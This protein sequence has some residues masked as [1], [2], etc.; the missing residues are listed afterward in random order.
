MADKIGI[1]IIGAGGIA[2]H[3]H[4][5]GYLQQTDA[6]VVAVADVVPERAQRLAEQA[7]IPH[8][9]GAVE[10]LL[11]DTDVDAVSVTTPNAFHGPVTLA[12][13]EAGKHVFCEKPPATSVA[14]VR[15]MKATAERAGKI[16]YFCLNNRFRPDVIQLR[17]YVERGELGEIYYAKTATLRRR[18]APGGW[19]ADKKMA[20]GGALID[21]GVHCIDWTLWI[22][23]SP[24]PVEIFGATYSKIKKYE[25]D[26]HRTWSPQEVRGQEG[27]VRAGDVDD[28]ATGLVRFANGATLFAE[29]SWSLNLESEVESTQVFGTRAGATLQPLKLFRDEY[30]R[31]VNLEVKLEERRG[32]T[33]HGRAIRN[34]LDVIQ[35]K[36]EPVVTPD[37]G[38]RIMQIL[39]GIYASA[40]SGKSIT[41]EG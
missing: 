17:R 2:E 24:R 30:G 12:A 8:A 26:D 1:G 3:S 11:L 9:Y 32:S 41:V 37:D 25:L 16:L 20:G 19:F 38:I 6:Q 14:E 15:R 27:F 22:M 18:G 39:D 35:G 23:G 33:S 21:I 29:V 7:G 40:E 28:A 5:P 13:L 4:I 34:F 36:A 10:D 31:M